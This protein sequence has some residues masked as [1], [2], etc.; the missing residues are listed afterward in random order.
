MQTDSNNAGV[1]TYLAGFQEIDVIL[2]DVVAIL[3]L[4]RV[5]EREVVTF[6]YDV[7]CIWTGRNSPGSVRS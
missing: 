1:A 7:A 2:P 3:I 5:A 6:P 4:A